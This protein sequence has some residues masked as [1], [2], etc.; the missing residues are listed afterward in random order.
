MAPGGFRLVDRR[1][2]TRVEAIPLSFEHLLALVEVAL[3]RICVRVQVVRVFRMCVGAKL[4]NLR[5]VGA[6]L[7]LRCLTLCGG[8]LLVGDRRLLLGVEAVELRLLAVFGGD[9]ALV[10]APLAPP[11]GGLRRRAPR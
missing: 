9:Y 7:R 5:R 4:G 11:A 6:L 10:L 8:C 1:P 3:V 2:L